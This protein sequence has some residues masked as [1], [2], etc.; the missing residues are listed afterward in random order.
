MF[1]T[2]NFDFSTLC[3]LRTC[4]HAGKAVS[5]DDAVTFVGVWCCGRSEKTE[6][7]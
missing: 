7:E 3:S 6:L 2:M 5:A 1:D 4:G